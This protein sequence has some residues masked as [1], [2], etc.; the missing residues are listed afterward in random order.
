MSTPIPITFTN[1]PVHDQNNFQFRDRG[2]IQNSAVD[3]QNSFNKDYFNKAYNLMADPSKLDDLETP[4]IE[5][6]IQTET[7][8]FQRYL[9]LLSAQYVSNAGY[10]GDLI[11]NHSSS[12]QGNI[13]QM[14][15]MAAIG[16]QLQII[17]KDNGD[18]VRMFGTR[19]FDTESN[20]A[21]KTRVTQ[22]MINDYNLANGTVGN[23]IPAEATQLVF[24]PDQTTGYNNNPFAPMADSCFSCMASSCGSGKRML[25]IQK[26]NQQP[27]N[28][29]ACSG[30]I[31][32]TVMIMD[33]IRQGAKLIV[34]VR[35]GANGSTNVAANGASNTNGMTFDF[36]STKLEVGDIIYVGTI[37]RTTE[38]NPGQMSCP[39][40]EPKIYSFC[41]QI[42]EFEDCAVCITKTGFKTSRF[43]ELFTYEKAL[44]YT[45]FKNLR[46]FY[47]RVA[48]DLILGSVNYA[49]GYAMPSYNGLPSSAN[50]I[51]PYNTNGIFNLHETHSKKMDIPLASCNDQC[52]KVAISTVLNAVDRS[53]G[54]EYS[55][56]INN[57][58]GYLLVGDVSKF[59]QIFS[60][61]LANSFIPTSM[62]GA[63]DQRSLQTRDWSMT[64]KALMNTTKPELQ[65][66]INDSMDS[67]GLE[68][69]EVQI[70]K[71][72]FRA[73]EDYQMSIDRPGQMDLYHVPSIK[74]FTDSLDE[75]YADTLGT[76][77]FL[78]ATAAKGI[79]LPNIYSES[80]SPTML[81][82]KEVTLARGDCP[83]SYK[84]YMRMGVR[85]APAKLGNLW[86]F[87]L[88]SLQPNPL[89]GTTPTE[90]SH[91]RGSINDIN[92]PG[93]I[94][95]E[96]K[97]SRYLEQYSQ[98]PNGVQVFNI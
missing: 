93:C 77:P 96:E 13:F 85:F 61:S 78:P 24:G 75:K 95:V 25:Y 21:F 70:G 11:K 68:F 58:K 47:H 50:E 73:L 64:N 36:G 33:T 40:F 8:D 38:C 71:L 84:Y 62:Q 28:T 15:K 23:F 29:L 91:I 2:N 90:P 66:Q 55:R 22:Q 48:N 10:Y 5:Y 65:D 72:K 89:F 44:Q 16:H 49:Q 31:A 12:T 17:P 39:T 37:A 74:M 14:G 59:D 34:N 41:D 42:R 9:G 18:Q 20:T 4:A 82:G 94:G 57:D 88:S 6:G 56:D 67:M 53:S 87:R 81:N 92:C 63:M 35:R 32:E 7:Y 46:N 60:A 1:L 79:A 69:Y 83:I 45:V 86:S 98:N 30:R 97:V 51:I 43:G 26:A 80:F 27:A 76:N 3:L 52:A 54:G 19:I